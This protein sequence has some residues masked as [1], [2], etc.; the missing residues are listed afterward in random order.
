MH[1]WEAYRVSWGGGGDR[2]GG[3]VGGL[4][5]IHEDEK[6][7]RSQFTPLITQRMMSSALGSHPLSEEEMGGDRGSRTRQEVTS[8]GKELK[9]KRKRRRS[10][11]TA[12]DFLLL[13]LW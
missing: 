9:E 3:G 4:G 5:V 7:L 8:S 2:G 10:R 12:S 11:Q 13:L 1:D 6:Q